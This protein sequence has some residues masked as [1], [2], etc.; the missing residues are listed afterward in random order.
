MVRQ[1]RFYEL[2]KWARGDAETCFSEQKGYR[3]GDA[4]RCPVSGAAV[5]MLTWL[6]PFRVE[7]ELY[8]KHF[9]DL[10]L[11]VGNSF[12]VSQKFRQA[13]YQDGLT[14]LVGFDPVEVTKVK[15]KSRR[16][17][18]SRPP[19]YFRVSVMRGQAALDMAASGFEWVEPPTCPQC[20]TGNIKR[21][22]RLALEPAT[23]TGEDAFLPWG[24]NSIVVSQRFKDACERHRIKNAVFTSAEEAGHDFYPGETGTDAT[25]P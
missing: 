10:A 3:Q 20:R 2:R 14:G 15:I 5:S 8:G 24:S 18:Q 13:Y 25:T 17:I 16:K 21:W 23:W 1:V 12:L 6:P 9:G 11:D 7:L 19:M 22:K 4:A